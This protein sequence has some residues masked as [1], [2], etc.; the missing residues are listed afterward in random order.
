MQ[1]GIS[2]DGPA[3]MPIQ[4]CGEEFSEDLCSSVPSDRKGT[5]HGNSVRIQCSFGLD[6]DFSSASCPN[7]ALIRTG[8]GLF[9]SFLSAS[10]TH[11]DW[12]WTFPRLPVRIRHSFG[13]GKDFSSASCPNPA[14]IRTGYGLFFRFL[15]ESGTHS[16]RVRAFPRLPVRTWHPT[17]LLENPA[18]NG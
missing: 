15:S 9:F 16:D 12:I 5:N 7:P 8:Y 14:L 4:A 1:S 18:K 3:F 11:S 13:Q 6:M 2:F 10:G 17:D